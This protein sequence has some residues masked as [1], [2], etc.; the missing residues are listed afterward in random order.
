[1]ENTLKKELTRRITSCNKGGMIVV[2][3]DIFF[4]YA[5]DAIDAGLTDDYEE[6]K[7]AC[8]KAQAAVM[9][10]RD[11]LDFKYELAYELYPI[12]QFVCEQISKSIY[13][14]SIDEIHTAKRLMNN[15]YTAFEAVAK[16]D[17]SPPLMQHAQKVIAGMTYKNGNLTETLQGA[18]ST[19][20]FLA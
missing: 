9:R 11:G 8:K 14:R 4:A 13:K 10:L 12:Y 3:Y 20:G 19:R 5:N 15:L 7:N 18:E 1:M 17:N 16:Q 2:I 6:F